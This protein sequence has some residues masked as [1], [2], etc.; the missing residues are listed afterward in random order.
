MGRA[1]PE[2][3]CW[4]CPNRAEEGKSQC[5]DCLKRSR[6]R[7]QKRR[8][9]KEV[10]GRCLAVPP[11][12]GKRRCQ[13]CADRDSE[14]T[15]RQHREHREAAIAAYGGNCRCCGESTYEFLSLD[16]I[17]GGGSKHRRELGNRNIYD[18]LHA[19]NY[20][21]IALQVL[22]HNCNLAKGFYGACPHE[23]ERERLAA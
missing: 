2:G 17:D 5:S 16:H 7:Q 19:N 13:A 1:R 10:C 14:E 9:N 4:H 20:P 22:C 21:P 11:V 23:A 15:K 6:E 8:K 18:W 3:K 12:P